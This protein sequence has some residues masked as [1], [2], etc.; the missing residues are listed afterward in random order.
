[1]LR[2][3]LVLLPSIAPVRWQSALAWSVIPASV[4]ETVLSPP[5]TALL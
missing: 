4:S 5:D 2:R 3:L 1:M